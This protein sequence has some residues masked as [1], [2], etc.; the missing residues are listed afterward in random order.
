MRQRLVVAMST[1]KNY[2]MYTTQYRPITLA[3]SGLIGFLLVSSSFAQVADRL[4][5]SKPSA[6]N[7][8]QSVALEFGDE[9]STVDIGSRREEFIFQIP[10]PESEQA[11]ALEMLT[12]AKAEGDR[13]DT[14][15]FSHLLERINSIR[16]P[17][18]LHLTLEDA[19]RLA[20]ANNF[21]I[22]VQSYNPAVET[23]RVIEAQSQFDAVFFTN[24]NKNKQ[25]R[26]TGSQLVSSDLD[27]F[28]SAYG[29]RK[30][31]PVGTQVT[32]S[33]NLR[34]TKTSLSFQQLNPEYFSEFIVE[35][36]HPFLRGSGLDYNRSVILLRNND[37]RISDFEFHVQIRDTLRRVE[38]LYW[39][40]A[41]ARR[42]VVITARLLAQ[43][44]RIYQY[45]VAR[46]D[47]D[48]VPVQLNAT[49]ANLETNLADFVRRRATVFDAEDRLIAELSDKHL[50]LADNIEIIP[51]DF[52]VMDRIVVER[53]AEVQAALDHRPEINQQELR[54]SSAKIGVGRAKNEEM[55]R[56]DVTF[57]YT[58]SGIGNNAD[59]SFN[60]ATKSNFIDYFVGVEFEL[61]VGNRGRR[62]AHQRARLQ[63]KQAIAQLRTII[64]SV[65]LDVNLATRELSTS[66]EQ[67]GP[68]FESSIAREKEVASLVARAERKDFNS[69]NS[70]LNAN[71]ALADA[72]RNML[73]FLINY[74]LAIID[75]ERAKGTL[76]SYNNIIIAEDDKP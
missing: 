6:P 48:I 50:N 62:A 42:D 56:L 70:E 65:I 64:E 54:V 43:F 23:T 59:L 11:D 21:N 51:D 15:Y 24:I 35:V 39:R 30:L 10:D 40:I 44:E 67:I 69:L 34:R 17:N 41:Q 5:A 63:H 76:L 68:S 32:G 49:K 9:I 20:M 22:D 71:R 29:L 14:H 61:P 45:L 16:R 74:N 12:K 52:P 60:G 66:F 18:Q 36:R 2:N 13:V 37:Q 3:C 27:L 19:L 55:P 53:L 7:N 1:G 31:L 26:P 58:S 72:R 73:N 4:A 75:L 47:F 25:D 46:K 38:E 33:Y 8:S 57:R 28:S